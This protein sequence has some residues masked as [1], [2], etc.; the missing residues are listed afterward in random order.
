MDNFSILYGFLDNK[1]RKAVYF[2]LVLMIIGMLLETVG[3]G[4]VIPLISVLIQGP[5]LSEYPVL[6]KLF[7][8]IGGVPDNQQLVVGSMLILV[9]FFGFKTIFL[10]FLAWKQAGFIF[11]M[12]ESISHRLLSN[13]L[14]QPYVFHLS[15][16]SA[17]LIRN[18]INETNLL[19]NGALIQGMML[20]TETMVLAGI[21]ILLIAVEPFGAIVSIVI[22]GVVGGL[23]H[24][25]VKN[26]LLAWGKARQ[27]SEG[28][29]IQHL[30]QG[31]G[32]AKEVKLLGCE[33]TFID[34]F[35]IHNILT[36][37]MGRRQITVQVFP[38]LWLEF[39]AVLGL[40][41]MVLTMM[42]NGEPIELLLPILGLF[43]AAAFKIMPSANRAII[44]LQQLRYSMPVIKTIHEELQLKN[45]TNIVSGAN[46]EDFNGKVEL[47][48]I[49]YNYPE[50]EVSVIKNISLNIPCKSI[51]GFVGKS[52]AG[53][54]TLIDLI[55]G[56]L[57]PS[58]GT[59]LVDGINIASDLRNW[60][61]QIGYVPQTVYLTD[62]TLR[63]NI[64]FG[65]PA[66]NINEE[67]IKNALEA[68][69]LTEFVQNLKDGLDAYVGER[70]IRLSGGQRQRIGIAR[71]LY[72]NPS[73]LVLD[74]ATSSL[75]VQTEDSI[76]STIN[77]LKN[78]KTIIIISHRDATVSNCDQIYRIEE[79]CVVNKGSFFDVVEKY[80]I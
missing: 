32:G 71:A 36:A 4:I 62:D 47:K 10:G 68:A 58:R 5:E 38:R 64:A 3:I 78:K 28:M 6:E 69:Q 56:L 2:I 46:N 52:G 11:G 21:S 16:N 66:D 23:F 44:S 67:A 34:K 53:K 24:N 27:T 59:I 50:S 12:Q 43:A 60:Q 39:I 63:E 29:R 72:N 61:K 40:T 1:Q 37:K 20:L 65:V 49:F 17:Q 70:G 48:N 79:G 9:F 8:Y 13:Y 41:C 77:T 76:I 75:D 57:P 35:Q 22:M 80:K 31:L 42:A 25:L 74:E 14:Y 18:T 19:T 7:N 26:R 73:V 15:R 55:L 33:E 54:S 30:Q 45:P 51:I